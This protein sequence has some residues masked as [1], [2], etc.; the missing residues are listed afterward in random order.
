MAPSEAD[1]EFLDAM[2]PGTV[3]MSITDATVIAS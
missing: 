3:R 2:P 1:Q